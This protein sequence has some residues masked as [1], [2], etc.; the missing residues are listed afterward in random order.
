MDG[1]TSNVV[2]MRADG[3]HLFHCI[4]IEDTELHIV[5][6]CND[7]IRTADERCTS[8]RLI[9]YFE[10]LDQRLEFKRRNQC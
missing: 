9:R 1:D 2:L 7:P 8:H 6:S 10:R 3:N 5:A 4:V